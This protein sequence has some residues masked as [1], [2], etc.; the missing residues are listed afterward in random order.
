MIKK[1]G[2]NVARLRKHARVRKKIKGT[3]ERPRLNVYRSLTN[4]YAQ[5][6]DDTTGKTLVAASSLDSSIKGKYKNCGNKEVAREVGKLLGQ[7]A[8]KEG[9]KKVVFDR[10]GYLY[11]GRVK[12]FAEGA[13]EAGLEF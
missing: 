1:P 3:T 10:G 12:E 6:I 2:K 9:I 13:R 11:H 5:V 8:I 4:F 7:K